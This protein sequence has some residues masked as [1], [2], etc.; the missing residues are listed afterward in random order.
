MAALP[1][2]SMSAQ[3]REA[4]ASWL[5][6]IVSGILILSTFLGAA[7]VV[8]GISE[9]LSVVESTQTAQQRTND[10]N[11]LILSQIFNI[12]TDIQK[13]VAEIKGEL[14]GR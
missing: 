3:V 8:N 11:T 7:N 10:G 13:D 5:K 1:I 12:L 6:I 2:P 14:K 9:R 4:I